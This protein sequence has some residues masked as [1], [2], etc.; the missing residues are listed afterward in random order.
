MNVRLTVKRVGAK[1][2][3]TNTCQLR[4]SCQIVAFQF[5]LLALPFSCALSCVSA[6][7]LLSAVGRPFPCSDSIFIFRYIFNACFFLV[8]DILYFTILPCLPLQMP[9]TA[10]KVNLLSC[11]MQYRPVF[12]SLLSSLLLCMYL[13]TIFRVDVFR[14]S[15]ISLPASSQHQWNC[16]VKKNR[17]FIGDCIRIGALHRI[18]SIASNCSSSSRFALRSVPAPQRALSCVLWAGLCWNVLGP[19]EADV[20]RQEWKTFS[21]PLTSGWALPEFHLIC[22]TSTEVIPLCV[23]TVLLT[24][25]KGNLYL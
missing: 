5:A 10:V 6:V 25:E 20:A 2:F 23:G 8:L 16:I 15:E 19:C 12:C 14:A 3:P 1:Q 11:P 21:C 24:V 9:G 18:I 4:F 17:F 7:L 13:E 22:K